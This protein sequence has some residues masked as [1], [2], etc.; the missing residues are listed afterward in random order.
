LIIL[1]IIGE[2]YKLRS[3]S[4]CSFLQPQVIINN[5]NMCHSLKGNCHLLFRIVY[6]QLFGVAEEKRQQILNCC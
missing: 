4:L 5:M 2:D 3:S 6:K 1:V